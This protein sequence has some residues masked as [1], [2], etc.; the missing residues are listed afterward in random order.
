MRKIL[1]LIAAV[2]LTVGLVGCS[3]KA[4]TKQDAAIPKKVL[5]NYFEAMRDKDPEKYLSVV[6]PGSVPNLPTDP[7]KLKEYLVKLETTSGKFKS[8]NI[9]SNPHYDD[10]NGQSIIKVTA[11]TDKYIYNLQFDV[12]RY[13][14]KWS[15]YSIEGLNTFSADGKKASKD[16][17]SE[18]PKDNFHSQLG[19]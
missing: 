18:M 4:E 16:S 9:E 19:Q 3:G 12:R 15:I 10:I 2:L 1:V 14:D 5:N 6:N 13:G 8:W 11:T 17:Q 7:A